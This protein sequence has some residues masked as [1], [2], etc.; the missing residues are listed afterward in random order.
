M[1]NEIETGVLNIV[2]ETIG[3]PA[4]EVDKNA[5][6]DTVYGLD[7]LDAVEMMMEIE[8]RFVVYIPDND[9]ENLKTVNQIIAYVKSK[10]R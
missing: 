10:K 2:A 7:S 5:H 3:M 9:V 8:E 1:S 4:Q 6:I